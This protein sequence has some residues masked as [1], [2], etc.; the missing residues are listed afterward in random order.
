MLRTV[1]YIRKSSDE[2]TDKQ[3]ESLERQWRDLSEF[4][5][6][7]NA[8]VPISEQLIFNADNDIIRE[9]FSAK[10]PWRPKFNKMIADIKKKKYDVL[11]SHEPSRLSR[12][13]IDTGVLTYILDE[14]YL[15]MIR[16]LTST[17]E[18]TPTDKFTL[19]LFLTVSKF[20]NDTRGANTSSGMQNQ[21]S[22]G[23][24]TNLANMGYINSWEWKWNRW[25]KK[26]GEN[27]NILRKC[28]EM[29][30]T[31]NY[32]VVDLYEYAVDKGFN[33]VA[34]IH[35]SIRREVPLQNS[36][37]YIFTN[38]YY[39][40]KVKLGK[41]ENMKWIEWKHQSMVTEKEF[42]K[43]QIILQKY[44]FKHSKNVEIKYE[45]L[46][47]SILHCW[48]SGNRFYVDIK[49]RYYCPT[50]SCSHRYFSKDG[51]KTCEKCH[52]VYEVDKYKVETFR[53]F[54][55]KGAKHT[56]K[57]WG[58]PASNIPIEYIESAVDGV[59]S[60]IALP[61]SIYEIIKKRLYTLWLESEEKTSKRISNLRKEIRALELKKRNLIENG[62]WGR[63][64]ISEGLRGTIEDSE[65]D[66][67]IQIRLKDSEIIRVRDEND[68]DFELAWQNL[69]TLL[70]A[71]KVF[72]KWSSESFEP[73][74]DL[75]L[76]LFS[77][78]KFIDWKIIPEWK[79]PF[80]TIAKAQE[81][82]K[83]K[84]Q[85]KSRISGVRYLWLPE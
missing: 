4:I 65:K 41:E 84:S 17:F 8:I 26:D 24:T 78:L 66:I 31:W 60:K 53:Y 63:E 45:N 2:K 81:L 22:K 42:E 55:V 37:R 54:A 76:S 27:F 18:N 19:S 52:H 33:R 35:P 14:E 21:K 69:N 48:K 1:I 5:E 13:P 61:D 10:T 83:Q 64:D 39:M 9:E 73:K 50:K 7:H 82:T 46:L 20:E 25:I 6:R 80:S 34:S 32:K 72:W 49:K 28:W 43:A 59:L 3:A 62:F 51:P 85:T 67:S 44:G 29:L 16:T 40:W 23:W 74:R 36:F 47:E 15:L 77:N 68:I 38:P 12:N 30:L 71:K 11:L 57:E 56:Y 75:L 70:E 79:E 58:K